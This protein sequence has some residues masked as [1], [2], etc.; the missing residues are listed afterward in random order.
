MSDL[1]TEAAR[2][3]RNEANI[4]SRWAAGE[5]VAQIATATGCT[6]TEIS[7][8]LDVIAGNNR[9]RAQ[10]LATLWHQRAQAVQAAKGAPVRTLHAA[11]E[12]K[13]APIT[14]PGPDAPSHADD[15][16]TA[17]A[18][19]GNGKLERTACRIR[20]QLA[21]LQAGLAEHQREARLRAE[22]KQLETRLAEIRT[23]LKTGTDADAREIRTWA[24]ANGVDC[25]PRGRIPA[26]VL[27]QYEKA[28]AA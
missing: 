17:A 1:A 9:N 24:A 20:E 4:C 28:A 25:P 7:D 12:P 21:D 27:Q 3:T 16:L 8:F 11:P 18:R 23:Q 13:P 6:R 26:G 14:A 15:L 10:Q 2:M 19:S 22:M 5:T